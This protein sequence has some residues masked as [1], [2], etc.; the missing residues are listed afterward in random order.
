M[1]APHTMTKEEEEAEALRLF[2]RLHALR[3]AHSSRSGLSLSI[4]DFQ[5]KKNAQHELSELQIK[6]FH[7]ALLAFRN[8]ITSPRALRKFE[9]DWSLS[10]NKSRS[11]RQTSLEYNFAPLTDKKM[12]LFMDKVC[13]AASDR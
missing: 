8:N 9:S 3:R 5:H 4:G 11:M 13:S 12:R 10:L 6:R 1:K 7:R 2:S